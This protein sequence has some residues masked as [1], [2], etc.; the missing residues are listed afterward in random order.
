MISA[1]QIKFIRSLQQKKFRDQHGLFVAEGEKIARELL[2]SG[3]EARIICGLSSWIEENRNI[4]GKAE[5]ITVSPRELD[6]ISGLKTANKVVVVAEK[7]SFGLP[8]SFAKD[9]LV[10]MLDDIRD[11]GNLGTIIRTADWFGVRH[12]VCSLSTADVYNPKVVQ[13]S[14]GSLFR[15]KVHY[16]DLPGTIRD[17]GD[18]LSVYATSA[19]GDNIYK[20][21]LKLPAAL[22]IGNEARGVSKEAASLAGKMLSVP[23]FG[24][25]AESL[26][27]AVSCG[28]VMSFFR[29][30]A[31]E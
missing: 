21:S 31:G 16:A 11:P 9:E 12:L 6:R 20:S 3:Q 7:P 19:G 8:R 18:K 14:M 25:G 29:M 13:A 24:P 27:A 30:A 17:M 5:I 26:N 2:S 15:V 23:A 22:I 4:L 10:V 1:S 28:I